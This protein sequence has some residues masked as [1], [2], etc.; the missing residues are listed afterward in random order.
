MV[1][2][3]IHNSHWIHAHKMSFPDQVEIFSNRPKGY[4]KNDNIKVL[5]LS[6]EPPPFQMSL[7]EIKKWRHKFDLIL[8]FREDVL[9]SC[10][11]ARKFM[12]GMTWLEGT[13]LEEVRDFK[14]K[15]PE[16]SF[17][18]GGKKMLPGHELRHKIWYRQKEI[19]NNKKFW[20]S[21]A[22]P[23]EP[24]DNN[25]TLP[26]KENKKIL[27]FY[28]QFHLAIENFSYKNYFTEKLM[29]CF[30]SK[31]IPIYFGAPNI[32]DYFNTDGMLIVRNDE[33]AIRACNNINENIYKKKLEHVEDNYNRCQ[34]YC[35]DFSVRL[36]RAINKHCF[37]RDV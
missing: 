2:P 26:A 31:T 11:N 10:R 32:G 25:P 16:T 13:E 8:T 21:S 22:Q 33:Q 19:K 7:L 9:E 6:N 4:R 34:E 28:S 35:E 30:Y 14:N 5:N 27:L 24:I 17:L 36:N 1:Y 12:C 3:I 18:C 15:R 37:G 29:D 20:I 23:I